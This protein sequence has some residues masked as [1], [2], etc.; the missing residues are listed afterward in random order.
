MSKVNSN[1]CQWCKNHIICI[2]DEFGNVLP[3]WSDKAKIDEFFGTN[4]YL[5][6]KSTFIPP[7]PDAYMHALNGDEKCELC[8]PSKCLD[9]G[10]KLL[11]LQGGD[12]EPFMGC[13]NFRT[14]G[15]SFK[16]RFKK[17]DEE[18][19]NKLTEIE[20]KTIKIE[21]K[22]L[23]TLESAVIIPKQTFE[24]LLKE[25][26]GDKLLALYSTYYWVAKW[27]NTNQPW[28][29][30]KYMAKKLGWTRETVSKYN[31]ILKRLELIED[32]QPRDKKTGRLKKRYIKVKFIIKNST[33][34]R[35][36]VNPYH[37]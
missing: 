4:K 24:L 35:S 22:A 32:V 11:K 27:Q 33:I 30:L 13:S 6:D 17:V 29:T 12:K 8:N 23:E 26:G 14:N 9:C 19:I 25:R 1:R 2:H 10:G 18:R 21:T 31:K 36:V 28:A 7:C 3:E 5:K 34:G 20:A 15:C 16:R 37:G